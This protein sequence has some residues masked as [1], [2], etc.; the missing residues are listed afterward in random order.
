MWVGKEA[1]DDGNAAS[2]DACLPGC[3]AAKC[4]DGILQTSVESCD[5]GNLV[6]GDFC[7]DVCAFECKAGSA[8]KQVGSACWM[9]FQTPATW[10]QAAGACAVMGAHLAAIQSATDA[11]TLGAV[12]GTGEAWIG[13]TDQLS[14][15]QFLWVIDAN[16]F[17][18]P[19]F[20]GFAVGQPDNKPFDAADCV[21]AGSGGWTDEVCTNT[22]PY[23]CV[24][25]P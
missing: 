14:E 18:T 8:Q 1:C 9:L 23:V 6:A 13:L 12:L 4:G 7:S 21:R 11:A 2:D 17:L 22:L 5:D 25:A 24:H 3:V 10:G 15:G 19:A 20:S 16:T